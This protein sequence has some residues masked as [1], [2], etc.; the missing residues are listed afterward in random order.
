MTALQACLD[1]LRMREQQWRADVR[2][3]RQALQRGSILPDRRVNRKEFEEQVVILES[4][5]SEIP[6]TRR[7]IQMRLH[8]FAKRDGMD[9]GFW[10]GRRLAR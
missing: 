7:G 5:L 10:S 6:W 4:Q 8:R 3:L 9:G 1:E 2:F